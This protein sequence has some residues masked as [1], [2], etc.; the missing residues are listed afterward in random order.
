MLQNPTRVNYTRTRTMTNKLIRQQKRLSEKKALEEMEIYRKNP[1]MF[2]EKC[3]SIKDGFK[4]RA[5]IMKDDD[6]NLL[7]DPE[8]IINNFGNYFERLL[9]NN[10]DNQYTNYR[11]Y[12]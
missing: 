11:A 4:A 6:N 3:A 1:R 9:N 5:L 10:N 8:Q 7:S 12:E 2:F